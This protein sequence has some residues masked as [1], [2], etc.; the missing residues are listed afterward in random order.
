MKKQCSTLVHEILERS[1][2]IVLHKP[3]GT[4]EAG[5]WA[6]LDEVANLTK[7]YAVTGESTLPQ[8]VFTCTDQAHQVLS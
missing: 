7:Y 8:G 6:G 5:K 1:H 4:C 3:D 2:R